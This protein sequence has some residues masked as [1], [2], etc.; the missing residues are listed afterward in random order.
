MADQEQRAIRAAVRRALAEDVAAG[1]VTS[2]WTLPES[3]RVRAKLVAKAPGV[4]AGLGV[5]RVV[6]ATVDKRI[7][8]EVWVPDGSTVQ[9]GDVVASLEGPA[10]SVLTAERV[11]LNFLQRMSGIATST[12]Q[13]V[14]AVQG[15]RAII[16]DTRKTAPGLR[17]LD[18]LAVRLGGG[19]NHRF[20]LFD[21]V[22]IKDN[23]IAAAGGIR[24]AVQR[25]RAHNHAGLTV[26]VEVKNSEE[27]REALDI[28][29]SHILLDNMDTEQMRQ[30]VS[31]TAGRAKLEASGGV[32]L[33]TVADIARTGVD[34]VSV[35]ALTHSV[36]AL[37]TSLEAEAPTLA[38]PS[39]YEALS[40]PDACSRIREAK[41]L[42][43]KDLVI[44]GH[45]YQRD[46]V[47]QFADVQGDSLELSREATKKAR[48][49]YIVFC[50][51][52]FMAETAAML[53]ASSQTVHIPET[54]AICPMAQMASAENLGV[55]WKYL[56]ELW[57]DDLTPV[58]YQNS[59]AEVKAFCG[60]HGGA[61]CTS[62][63]AQAVL[64]WALKRTRHA[65]FLPDEHLGRNSALAL[66]VPSDE[67][68]IWDPAQPVA[69]RDAARSATVVVW[70]GY[71]NVHTRFTVQHVQEVRRRH[72][73][74]RV[75]V[76]PECPHEVVTASDRSGSTSYIMRT[77]REA[78]P[79]SSFAVGTE[80]HMVDRLARENP[81][82][83]IVPLARSTCEAMYRINPQNLSYTLDHLLI[84]EPVNVVRVPASISEQAN[85]ALQRMLTVK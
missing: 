21:M 6:F 15:T 50:G 77:V 2:T 84:G 54:T 55:A 51:V 73:G 76:H 70:K 59:Y 67:I 29:V 37:D 38:A 25:V 28:G 69:S 35:G 30:A 62:A 80:V 31:F 20:G 56:R 65:I 53:C 18:K 23:H 82:K 49:R 3:Q 52:D 8:F 57:D 43:G 61:V 17:V 41:A 79:A 1:D 32:N 75:I 71:C 33:G 14:Q 74:I 11:A 24:A 47:L 10:Q 60:Q 66:G 46:E 16:L 83:F 44:L 9:P 85:L 39:E 64:R 42:L 19:Q 45:H 68:S 48:A 22:L 72:P 40:D 12:R 4:I 5:A 7:R 78:P 63:N 27:L 58:T 34:Y 81:D 13:Y 36:T 26:E